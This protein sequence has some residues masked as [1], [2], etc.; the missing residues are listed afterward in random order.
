MSTEKI[1]N[2]GVILILLNGFYKGIFLGGVN[3][4]PFLLAYLQQLLLSLYGWFIKADG[5][6]IFQRFFRKM[7]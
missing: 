4:F 5:K 6:C 3:I 2:L 7:D 1:L